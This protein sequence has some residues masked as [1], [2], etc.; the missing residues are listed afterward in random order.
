MKKK[1]STVQLTI[2]G[3]PD[4]IAER[5]KGK[6]REQGKSL[7]RLVVEA[8]ITSAGMGEEPVEFHDLDW[9]AGSWVEDPEFDEAV[10]SFREVDEELWR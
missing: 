5:L 9:I 3:I 2:R 1:S 7:N 4:S 8:L 6:A 10:A